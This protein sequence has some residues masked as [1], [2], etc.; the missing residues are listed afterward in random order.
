[1]TAKD[2]KVECQWK[3][4][5]CNS[6]AI[7]KK[8]LKYST[9]RMIQKQQVCCA[10]ML[11]GRL[12]QSLNRYCI[13]PSMK[14]TKGS[15]GML[16]SSTCNKSITGNSLISQKQMPSKCHCIIIL[17]QSCIYIIKQHLKSWETG[18]AN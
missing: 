16:T 7:I 18:T 12:L 17:F 3:V 4:I 14:S 15:Y 8:K 6:E 13:F 2:L 11:L 10:E 1:M 5:H 9:S